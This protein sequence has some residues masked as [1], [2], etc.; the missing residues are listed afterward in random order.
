MKLLREA[1]MYL[2]E[3]SFSEDLRKQHISCATELFRMRLT[4]NL[5]QRTGTRLEAVPMR[6]NS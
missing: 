1:V 2:T 3:W 6:P 4:V 5:S